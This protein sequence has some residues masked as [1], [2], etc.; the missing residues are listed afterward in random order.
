MR[1]KGRVEERRGGCVNG[2]ED[3]IGEREREGEKVRVEEME[4]RD[5][6]YLCH[7]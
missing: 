7:E 5:T 3:R 4:Q 6:Y 2:G 1:Y